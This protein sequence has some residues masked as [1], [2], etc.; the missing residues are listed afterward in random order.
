M[1]LTP[2][3][4]LKIC[5]YVLREAKDY[6]PDLA[7]RAEAVAKSTSRVAIGK[8]QRERGTIRLNRRKK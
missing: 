1:K 7:R 2:L 6:P 4:I 3:Q 8:L 5:E